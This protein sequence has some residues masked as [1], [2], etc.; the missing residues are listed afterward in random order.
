MSARAK[1]TAFSGRAQRPDAKKLISSYEH[2]C[3]LQGLTRTTIKTRVY[4]LGNFS[5]FLE[6]E[7]VH[8]L[9]VGRDD[10]RDWIEELKINR[11]RTTV[12][13]K[14]NLT[15][16]TGFY[17]YLVFEDLVSTNP[18]PSV[19]KRYMKSYKEGNESHSHKIISVEE[20]SELIR[21]AVDIRDRTFML[22]MAKTG[23]RRG[24]LISMDYND[25]NFEEQSI[26]LKPTPKRS[27]RLVYFD[28]E[29]ETLLRRWLRVR[30]NRNK[31]SDEALFISQR[32]S[33]LKEAGMDRVIIA[34]A[35]RLGLHDPR[36]DKLEDHFT[37]H[38]FRHWFVTHLMRAGMPREFVK[39]LRGD[40][41]REAIDIYNH[42]DKKDLRESY[43]AHIPQLGI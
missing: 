34:H 19:R 12:T 1:A 31:W 16:I 39:E 26:L 3:R 40:S 32:N 10:I 38:C 28:S 7:G 9:D 24:E 37:S 4:D 29:A 41:R 22:L 27:N 42:I 20:M 17:E 5:R 30:Q 8:I 25:I 23:V 14:N 21:S 18:V 2:D 6:T 11:K 13:T 43:L 15:S 35:Q 33:R 36:S